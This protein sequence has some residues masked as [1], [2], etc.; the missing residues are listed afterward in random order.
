MHQ[1][2]VNTPL[3]DESDIEAVTQALRE[4]WISGEGPIVANFVM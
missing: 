3:V 4:G 1:V 2:P